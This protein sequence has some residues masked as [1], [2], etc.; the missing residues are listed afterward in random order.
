MNAVAAGQPEGLRI[1]IVLISAVP[2]VKQPIHTGQALVGVGRRSHGTVV[3]IPVGV[4]G[5]MWIAE[6]LRRL[7]VTGVDVDVVIVFKQASAKIITGKAVT[8]GSS[9]PV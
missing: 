1:R 2:A 8:F 3:V 7:I 4:L 5:F 6:R 9:V